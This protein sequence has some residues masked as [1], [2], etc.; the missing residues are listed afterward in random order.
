MTTRR[1]GTARLRVGAIACVIVALSAC[2][3]DEPTARPATPSATLTSP[4]PSAIGSSRPPSST[5]TN[6]PSSPG[7]STQGTPAPAAR[8]DKACVRRATDTQGIT[9]V[10]T[11]GGPA[12]Y[13]TVYSDGSTI[14]DKPEE[15]ASGGQGAGF[16]G[17]DGR[18]RQTWTV[19]A[20]APTGEATV[21]V[22]TGPNSPAPLRFRIVGENERC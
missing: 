8:L 14:T 13:G 12:S 6:R 22:N 4:S 11:P 18:F 19:P 20:A 5:A 21:H 9:I 1:S 10:T 3:G 17:A 15:Y 2:G 16:A 7:K